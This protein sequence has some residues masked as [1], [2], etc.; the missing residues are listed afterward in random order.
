MIPEDSWKRL[1]DVYSGRQPEDVFAFTNAQMISYFVEKIFADGAPVNDD[2]SLNNS[3]L[4]LFRC[5]HIQDIKVSLANSF[6]NFLP[7]ACQR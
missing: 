5:G 7:S 3:P 4:S 1:I 2:K 6:L